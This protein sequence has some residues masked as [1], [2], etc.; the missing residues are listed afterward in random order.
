MKIRRA[1]ISESKRVIKLLNFIRFVGYSLNFRVKTETQSFWGFGLR[2]K[3]KI[4][5]G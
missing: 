4:S 1:A 5:G 3:K 2:Q